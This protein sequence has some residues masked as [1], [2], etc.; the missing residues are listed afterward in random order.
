MITSLYGEVTSE[1]LRHAIKLFEAGDN[2]GA[3]A[4]LDTEEIAADIDRSERGIAQNRDSIA[5]AQDLARTTIK[6]YH[7][8]IKLILFRGDDELDELLLLH[9]KRVDAAEKSSL[10]L[11]EIAA[12]HREF[13]QFLEKHIDLKQCKERLVVTYD[14]LSQI[15]QKLSDYYR[16]RGVNL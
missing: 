8:K 5:R 1:R 4:V 13:A 14:K 10:P 16:G 6:E 2:R 7:Q 11:E 9:Q 12:V 15:Y 3:D